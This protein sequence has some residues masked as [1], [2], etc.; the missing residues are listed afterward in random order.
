MALLISASN[1]VWPSGD[2]LA[3]R[4]QSRAAAARPV[5]D[6][7]GLAKRLLQLRRDLPGPDVGRAASRRR[8][9]DANRPRRIGLRERRSGAEDACKQD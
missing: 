3:R 8:H 7:E 2:A 1:S 5:L 9:Q 4:D 6:D